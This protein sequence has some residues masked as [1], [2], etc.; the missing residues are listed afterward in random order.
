MRTALRSQQRLAGAERPLV[1]IDSKPEASLDDMEDF[2]RRD[3]N[4]ERRRIISPSLVFKHR[5]TVRAAAVRLSDTDQRI[6]ESQVVGRCNGDGHLRAISNHPADRRR[7][8]YSQVRWAS[9]SS[10]Q[11]GIA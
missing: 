10:S 7:A 2:I 8:G 11:P 6:K 4:V 9:S 5:D 1:V 3:V